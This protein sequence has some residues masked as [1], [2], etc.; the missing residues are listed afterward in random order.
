M[1]AIRIQI[2]RGCD[3]NGEGGTVVDDASGV[4]PE[5]VLDALAAAFQSSYGLYSYPNP[6]KPEEIITVS[7]LRNISTRMRLFGEEHLLAYDKRMRDAATEQQAA[8]NA[9]AVKSSL[10]IKENLDP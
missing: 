5:P 8:A 9:A 7:P 10:I 3:E 6:D 4:I 1:D 2:I